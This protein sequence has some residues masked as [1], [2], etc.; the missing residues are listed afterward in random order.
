MATG[1]PVTKGEAVG[2]IAAQSIGEPG[3]QL[4]MRTF[5]T[6]GIASTEDITQGL[7]RV[8]ELFEAR[9]PKRCGVIAK[10]SGDI[11]IAEEK[12]SNV[13]VITNGETLQEEKIVIPYGVRCLVQSGDTVKAGDMLIPGAKAPQDILEAQGP[14]AVQEYI[15]AEIQNAYRTQGV[16]IN[17]KH[18]EVIIRQMMKQYK[19][20]ESGTSELIEGKDYDLER[21]ESENEAI[22]ARIDA[23]EENLKLAKYSATLLGIT[24]ASLATGSFLS[25]ASFQET[26]KVLTDAAIEGKVDP[27][28]GLKENVIIGNLVPAGTGMRVRELSRAVKNDYVAE[29]AEMPII[30]E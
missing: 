17:D 15:I 1:K 19:I 13:I 21:I 8:E 10:I 14:Q 22:Q 9:R 30:E 28:F 26:T 18:I 25:A 5:H 23:G 11:R 4:T 7:P 12:K 29:N 24:K 2:I 3:T 27:L 6:G 20:T 16:D